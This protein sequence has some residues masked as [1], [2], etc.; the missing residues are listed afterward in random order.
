MI[1]I[2]IF[3]N[4]VVIRIRTTQLFQLQSY[5]II[6]FY[7]VPKSFQSTSAMI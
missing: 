2:G 1:F 6:L 7:I 3:I 5:V 4:K